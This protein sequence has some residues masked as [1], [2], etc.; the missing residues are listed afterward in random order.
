MRN[1]RWPVWCILLLALAWQGFAKH[2]W[3]QV[4]LL[5]FLVFLMLNNSLLMEMIFNELEPYLH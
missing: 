5:I 1:A 4:T 2:R 3:F